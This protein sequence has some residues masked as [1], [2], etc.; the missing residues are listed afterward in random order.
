MELILIRHGQSEANAING[1]G[2]VMFTGRWECNLTE[3]GIQQ[4]MALRDAP[5]LM[6]VER[7]YTSTSLRARQ[8]AA[9]FAEPAQIVA[10]PR[11]QER[12]LGQFEGQA[13][14]E[15]RRDPAYRPYFTEPAWM[16]FRH[17]F[18]ARAPGGENYQDVCVRVAGF[19]EELRRAPFQKVAIV[20]HL[21]AIRCM[22]RVLTGCS[23]AQTL[24]LAVPQCK[25]MIFQLYSL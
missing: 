10:D 20:S 13:I 4:A 7:V 2:D 12:S 14:A 16:D 17:G 23:E 6:G 3:Y 25:P 19:L 8:T 9:C 18:G 11:L 21:C 15:I 22:V 24:Q 5:C 1:A